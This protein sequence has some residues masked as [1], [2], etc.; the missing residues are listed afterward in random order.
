MHA[1]RS[2]SPIVIQ[3]ACAPALR[4]PRNCLPGSRLQRDSARLR[5]R[6]QCAGGGAWEFLETPAVAIGPRKTHPPQLSLS[7]SVTQLGAGAG[8]WSGVRVSVLSLHLLESGRNSAVL[9][10]QLRGLLQPPS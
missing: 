10:G 2:P 9:L 5:G 7:D 3:R 4:S 6:R 8:S 1:P